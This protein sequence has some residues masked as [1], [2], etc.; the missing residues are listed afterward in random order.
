MFARARTAI[1]W[2]VLGCGDQTGDEV[3]AVSNGRGG[4]QMSLC[5]KEGMI[6]V[7]D[8]DRDGMVEAT[9]RH[10]FFH[11]CQTPGLGGVEAARRDEVDRT[12]QGRGLAGPFF[13][14]EDGVDDPV[15]A[16]MRRIDDEIVISQIADIDP[17]IFLK[18]P[19]FAVPAL[20]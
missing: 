19:D 18:S 20:L 4:P 5:D 2:F 10:G 6:D 16:D 14:A 7:E 15:G 13:R 8:F 3:E 11:A 1:E 12:D 9:L 17:V